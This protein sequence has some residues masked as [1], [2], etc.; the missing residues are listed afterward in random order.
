MV[1]LVDPFVANDVCEVYIHITQ[2][3]LI[4]KDQKKKQE[5][6]HFSYY[7]CVLGVVCASKLL[8]VLAEPNSYFHF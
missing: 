1:F 3:F 4:V 6:Y 2:S 8:C 5:T 7:I